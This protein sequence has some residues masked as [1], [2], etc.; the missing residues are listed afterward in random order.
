MVSVG[1][2]QSD[3]KSQIDGNTR[4]VT[5]ITENKNE[6][7]RVLETDREKGKLKWPWRERERTLE[8]TLGERKH[9][10][11]GEE[12]HKHSFLE[13]K[14]ELFEKDR[15]KQK[16]NFSIERENKNESFFG[17]RET[18]MNQC[19]CVGFFVIH[20]PF[21]SEKDLL[22]WWVS[23]VT[24]SGPRIYSENGAASKCSGE[25]WGCYTRERMWKEQSM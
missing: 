4:E 6:L 15:E 24:T 20:K 14:N 22:Q 18:K 9:T 25:G 16:G 3:T 13:N 10:N 2:W 19:D 1:Q 7:R 11:W 23:T 12:E 5:R 8:E 21:G 17:V